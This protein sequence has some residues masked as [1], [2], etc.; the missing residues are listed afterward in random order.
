MKRVF[1]GLM[2]AGCAVAVQAAPDPRK[3]PSQ[4]PAAWQAKTRE[5]FKQVIE[6]PSV[7]GRGLRLCRRR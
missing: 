1:A 3:V 6:T 2:L 4:L 5:L 7:E